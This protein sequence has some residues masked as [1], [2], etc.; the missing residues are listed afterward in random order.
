MQ[1][2]E[3]PR[4]GSTISYGFK[5]TSKKIKCHH[6]NMELVIDERTQRLFKYTRT[7]FVVVAASILMYGLSR[8]ESI[9]SYIAVIL[10]CSVMLAFMNF[11]E[12][13]CLIMTDKIFHLRYIPYKKPDAK[14]L[15]KARL[16]KQKRKKK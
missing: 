13:L 5:E 12:K 10:V 11:Y 2:V 3:C 4:C 14:E 15:K 1:K 7:F 16:A 6:C 8:L 9:S